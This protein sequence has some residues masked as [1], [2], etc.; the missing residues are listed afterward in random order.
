MRFVNGCLFLL[1]VTTTIT[2]YALPEPPVVPGD[3]QFPEPP[4][5]VTPPLTPN[6]PIKLIKGQYYVVR[7]TIPLVVDWSGVGEVT[8]TPRNGKTKPLTIP[9][10]WAVGWKPDDGDPEF[11]TFS[12]EFLYIVKASKTGSG[13]LEVI[14]AVTK[15]DKD[16]K[17]IPLTKSSI[18]R[19]R[20]YVDAKTDP[21]PDPDDPVIPVVPVTSF[22]VIFVYETADTLTTAQKSVIFGKSISDYL[23]V[24]TTKEDNLPGYR[25]YDKDTTGVNEQPT[26]RALWQAVKPKLTSTP[27]YVIEVN[28]KA[29][30]L[31]L[32]ATP[33]AAL[34]ELKKYAGDK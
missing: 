3:I 22:R 24:K 28:G 15:L 25:R 5:A 16:M 32:P 4:Q 1:A 11:V 8:I 17:Q 21:V 2:A 18:T 19:K 26:M 31:S 30:I 23:D 20:I 33:A 10:D 12:N 27:C 14:P 34:T 9:S 29:E 7:S 6:A 13:I